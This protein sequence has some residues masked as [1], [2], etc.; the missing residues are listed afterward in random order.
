MTH[1]ELIPADVVQEK[2]VGDSRFRQKTDTS[3]AGL[4]SLIVRDTV[5]AVATLL[6]LFAFL[7]GA[8]F[9]LAAS[10]APGGGVLGTGIGRLASRLAF[11]TDFEAIGR[12]GNRSMNTHPT[13]G[14]G[15]PPMRRP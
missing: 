4:E 6:A 7:I 3:E 13:F 1:D 11:F 5:L 15:L 14:T 9:C 2:L 8:G 12:T 10:R